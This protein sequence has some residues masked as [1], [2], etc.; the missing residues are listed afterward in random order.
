MPDRFTHRVGIIA[1]VGPLYAPTSA[2]PYGIEDFIGGI[3]PGLFILLLFLTP[4][5]WGGPMALAG[6]WSI[7]AVFLDNALYPVLYRLEDT[8]LV[9]SEWEQR[10]RGVPRKVYRLTMA[11]RQRLG[12]MAEAWRSF[13]ATIDSI[14][15]GTDPKEE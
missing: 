9:E 3:G 2:G 14:L 8:G 11:G 5:I 1:V 6:A 13:A 15:A 4:W 12:E 7:L 10:E